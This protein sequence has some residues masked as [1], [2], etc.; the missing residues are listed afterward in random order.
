MRYFYFIYN[1]IRKNKINYFLFNY[2]NINIKNFQNNNI[3]FL[4]TM[5]LN[6]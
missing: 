6:Y 3:K 2:Q 1:K 5:K 4:F